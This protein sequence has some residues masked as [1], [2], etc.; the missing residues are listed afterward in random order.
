MFDPDVLRKKAVE[1]CLALAERE[2]TGAF[3]A[4][5][6]IV[7]DAEAVTWDP[8]ELR[9]GVDQTVVL[10][11]RY[12]QFEVVLDDEDRV[13]GYEDHDKWQ[14][15]R[16]EPLTDDEALAVA[17]TSGLLRPGMTLVRSR[18]GQ[19]E[20]LELLL[21]ESLGREATADWVVRINPSRRAV[22]SF[23]PVEEDPA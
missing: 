10:W 18:K 20:C 5:P 11:R 6:V 12:S 14:K 9:Q 1:D 8:I 13:V 23:L 15:C 19:G 17:R 16:W 4:E 3:H 21:R 7:P 2:L 22:I